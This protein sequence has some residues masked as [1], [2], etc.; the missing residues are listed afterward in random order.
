MATRSWRGCPSTLSR[1]ATRIGVPELFGETGLLPLERRGVRPTLEVNGIWGGFS[2]EGSKTIIPA[3]AH[4]KIS[5]RLVAD[6][7]PHRT[8]ELVRDA[9]LAVGV[10]GV[11]VEVRLLN[12][13]M[14]SRVSI[15]HPATVAA[16]SAL[17]DVFGAD[18]YYLFEGGS[19]PAAASF[20]SLLGLPVVLLGFTNPDDQAHAP[21]ENMVLANYD[22][23]L[24]TIVRYWAALRDL[25]T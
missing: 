5:C 24:R 20:G 7:D 6:M 15:D 9:V 25:P 10:P 2:G 17:R 11:R 4:A 19:I 16:A 21:N 12:H 14:W 3:E 1:F 23:G 18:P 22:G 8:F 13:G